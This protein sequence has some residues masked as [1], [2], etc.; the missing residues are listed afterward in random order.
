MQTFLPYPDYAQSASVLDY[1]RLGKQ[2]VEC[3]QILLALQ[4]RKGAWYNHPATVMWRDFPIQL[5]VYASAMCHEWHYNRHYKDSLSPWFIN[6]R[7]RLESIGYQN[8]KPLWL[9]TEAFHASHR[10]NLLRKDFPFYS[11]YN[12]SESP[13]LP[14]L[15]PVLP[16]CTRASQTEVF[17]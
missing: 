9:G 1:R 14:Y 5:C 2:R 16:G 7:K 10:S 3:K 15:W 4:R 17:P 8:L 12:W 6:E 11:R 13:N